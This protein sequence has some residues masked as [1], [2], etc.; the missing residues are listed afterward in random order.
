MIDVSG[1]F[2]LVRYRYHGRICLTAFGLTFT[3]KE[4]FEDV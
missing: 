4:G 3:R 2:Q 1:L